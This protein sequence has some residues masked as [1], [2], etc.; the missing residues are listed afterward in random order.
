[1]EVFAAKPAVESL[2]NNSAYN[3]SFSDAI[4]DL[5]PVVNITPV[6]EGDTIDLGGM[7]LLIYETPGH[8]SR[9]QE[10][11]IRRKPI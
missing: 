11:F 5:K 10:E 7:E 4:T 9:I 1:M 3:E 6:K 2:Q 8:T